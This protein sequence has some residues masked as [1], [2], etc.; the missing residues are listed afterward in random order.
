MTSLQISANLP[1]FLVLS[2]VSTFTVTITIAWSL[3]MQ[4]NDED[5]GECISHAFNNFFFL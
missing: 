4:D 1:A 2:L 3:V 5:L